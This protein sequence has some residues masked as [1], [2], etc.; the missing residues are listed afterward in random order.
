MVGLDQI[1]IV[2]YL[3]GRSPQKLELMQ[4]INTQIL[5][6]LFVTNGACTQMR[7]I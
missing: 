1:M 5:N 6:F 2:I 4:K 3:Q 7:Y